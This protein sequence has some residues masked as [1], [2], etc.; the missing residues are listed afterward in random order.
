MRPTTRL[1][2]LI[3]AKETLI[4]P[5]CYNAMTAKIIEQT[6]FPGSMS[7]DYGYSTFEG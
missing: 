4:V 6:G 7:G 1:R 3:N 2:E 5:G